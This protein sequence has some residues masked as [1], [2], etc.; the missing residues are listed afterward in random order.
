[1]D[2]PILAKVAKLCLLKPCTSSML[3][4]QFG[5]ISRKLRKENASI[6][7]ETLEEQ[8]Q[9]NSKSVIFIE[10]FQKCGLA[11]VPPPSPELSE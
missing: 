7:A 5:E 1:M 8:V 9:S 11:L 3:E 4:R 2:F 10:G 6:Q